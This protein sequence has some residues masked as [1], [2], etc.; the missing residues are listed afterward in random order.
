[1]TTERSAVKAEKCDNGLNLKPKGNLVASTVEGVRRNLLRAIE[2]A[3]GHIVLD[4]SMVQVVDS[5]GIT[6][7]LGL[8][9]TC[10]AKGLTFEVVGLSQDIHRVFK[11]FNLT[12]FFPVVEASNV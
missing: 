11:L 3:G 2:G 10:K 5:M 1:M 4:M 7:V 12:K 6:L 8:F 9:K